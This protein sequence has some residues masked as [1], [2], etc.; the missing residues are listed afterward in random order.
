MIAGDYKKFDKRMPANV[1]LTAFDIIIDMCQ[2]AGYDKEDINVIRGIAYDTAFPTVDF[3][4]DLIEFYGSNPSGHALTVTINGIVNPI[5]MRYTYIILRPVNEKRDFKQLVALMTYGDDNA[6][7]VSSEAPWFNHTAIQTVLGEADIVYTMAEKGAISRPYINLSEVSFLKR[8]WRFDEDIGAIVAPL[9]H[10]SIVK[11]LTMCVYKK[12][13]SRECHAIAVISTAI[14]EYFWY[15]K[16]TFQEKS[17]M[18]LDVIKECNLEMYVE[19][20][21]LPTWEELKRDFWERSKHVVGKT[22]VFK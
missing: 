1:I 18:F 22:H 7:G 16:E 10:S 2:R 6:M 12:N 15:G 5:Y 14:R 11:M 4:G 9:D 19:D 20:D 21:T 17:E 8:T 3:N 13:I